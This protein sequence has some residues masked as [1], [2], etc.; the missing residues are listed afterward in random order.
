MHEQDRFLEQL[1]ATTTEA[2]VRK[3]A[4]DNRELCEYA[5]HL[6]KAIA[7]RIKACSPSTAQPSARPEPSPATEDQGGSEDQF[8][9]QLAA[10]T[11]EFEVRKLARDNR[12][13]CE[14]NPHLME[15]IRERVSEI[16]LDAILAA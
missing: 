15:A 11:T 3:L 13:L 10:I 7:E 8:L 14:P 4:R 5:P 12:S 2:E 6:L 16:Q 1:D 9:E